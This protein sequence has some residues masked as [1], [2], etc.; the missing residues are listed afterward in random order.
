MK[1]LRRSGLLLISALLLA[2]PGFGDEDA[3][4]VPDVPTYVDHVKPILDEHCV[5]CHVD[6]PQNG[7]AG[8]MVLDQ[9][10]DVLDSSG[11][12]VASGA[13]SLGC[14]IKFRAV[15]EQPTAMPPPPR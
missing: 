1:I 12:Q 3:G 10:A 8:G 9:Y 5:V 7:A 15:D 13:G 14:L 2:C 6:P 11:G 4:N